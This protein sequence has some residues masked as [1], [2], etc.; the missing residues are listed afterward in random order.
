[1]KP[2]VFRWL[3]VGIASYLGWLLVNLAVVVLFPFII[4]VERF[5]GYAGIRF[6]RRGFAAFFRLFFLRFFS[7]IRVYRVVELPDAKRLRAARP[8][9]FVSNHRS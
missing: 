6:L 8:A 5:G 3:T 9:M 4:V 2:S 1:M 7:L